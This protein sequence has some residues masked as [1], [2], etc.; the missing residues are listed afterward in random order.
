MLNGRACTKPRD[1]DGLH[2]CPGYAWDD[3]ALALPTDADLEHLRRAMV[4]AHATLKALSAASGYD[5]TVPTD[6]VERR[7]NVF[8][9]AVRAFVEADGSRGGA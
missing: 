8:R 2:G 9:A 6:V 3:A 1:H 7:R 4:D 5:V